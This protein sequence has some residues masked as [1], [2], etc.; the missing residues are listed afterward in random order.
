ML[1]KPGNTKTVFLLI[2]T[3][4]TAARVLLSVFPKSA[5]IYNDEL[6]YLELAQNIWQKGAATVYTM[7]LHFSKLLYP[8]LLAPFYAIRDGV[9]RTNLLSAFNA[10]LVS[11]SLI[12]GYLLAKRTLK[13]TGHITFALLFLALS[14]NL[15]LSMTFMAENLYYP[16]LLWGFYAAWRYLSSENKKPVHAFLLGLLA[17]ALYFAKE[18]GAAWAAGLAAALLAGRMGNKK[19]RKEVFLPLGLY[20]LGFV[21]P[22]LILRFTLL[23]GMGY[24]YSTQASF[25]N[26]T[27]ASQLLYFLYAAGMM[28]LFF[29]V[30]VLYFP[31]ILPMIRFKKLSPAKQ[32]LLV[33]A[34]SYTVI[35]AAG[36]AFGV[37]LFSDY[38]RIDLR[39]HL[40]YFLGAAFPF[41]LLALP[42]AEEAEPLTK[43]SP[44]LWHTVTF[45]GLLLVFLILPTVG[46]L[47]DLPALYFTTYMGRTLRW[48][49]L[50]KLAPAAV[51]AGVLLLWN[52][53]RKQAFACLLSLLL[54][55]ALASDVLFVKNGK[56]DMIVTDPAL[57]E[58]AK[59]M[60]Q[61]LDTAPGTTLVL[62]ETPFVPEL[63][64]L[65]TVSDDDY[66]FATYKAV[67]ETA[68]KEDVP[69]PQKL[70]YTAQPLP[71][72]I[73]EFTGSETYDNLSSVDQVVCIGKASLLDESQYEDVTPAN[74]SSMTVLK[75]KDKNA[76]A[77]RDLL[78]Y[79]L[80]EQILFYGEDPAFV[81]YRPM[82]FSS[83]EDSWCWTDGK[84]ASLTLRPQIQQPTDLEADWSWLM[85]HGEQPC[86]VYANDTLVLD[87]IATTDEHYY[88]FTIPKEAWPDGTLT[89]CFLFPE[90]SPP[91]TSDTRE[92]AVAFESLTLTEKEN[93]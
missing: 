89:L 72:P 1:K 26:L 15:F 29:L 78:A 11:S 40:R 90:A 46:S 86:Q 14:P 30:S 16:L 31:V 17:F 5:S 75:A 50:W 42:L 71:N 21:V 61:Y 49:W 7:P 69:D 13:K 92:L 36:M 60:D 20:L 87:E 58:E 53:K 66:A 8:L 25:S 84:E 18:V 62:A 41:L 74:V 48:Q 43:K 54:L 91:G 27:N 67:R 32:G 12:P 9:L 44:L 79:T 85:V 45:I 83:P 68:L 38:P 47:V 64:L 3:L 57:L 93:D 19:G 6:F 22:Y 73:P 56:K 34:V 35:V 10:L 88:L 37:S 2:L 82:G 65:N 28:L 77:L 24:S 59:A 39:V 4:S 33:L 80:G 63:R 52:K 76:L 23:S 81:C 70:S 55:F 51:L